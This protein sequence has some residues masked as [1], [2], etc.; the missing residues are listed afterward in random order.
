MADYEEI[1]YAVETIRAA[2][3]FYEYGKLD[4]LLEIGVT[5]SEDDLFE[6]YYDLLAAATDYMDE[7]FNDDYEVNHWYFSF[8]SM[9][10]YYRLI[11][12]Y[13]SLHSMKLSENPYVKK[14]EDMLSHTFFSCRCD[15]G[16]CWSYQKKIGSKWASGIIV[17]TDMY[18]S[19][20]YELLEVLL[21]VDAWYTE[22]VRK[23]E[24]LLKKERAL[25]KR[26]VPELEA[27]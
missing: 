18:F 5:H 17:E 4:R 24:A 15:F 19:S 3:L 27:A 20:E 22:E 11:R 8:R 7:K 16:M 1:A 9:M 10:Q 12:E 21:A 23:L 2:H 25:A 14:A 13:G 6:I 26:Y